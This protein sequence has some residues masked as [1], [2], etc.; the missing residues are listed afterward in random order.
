MLQD[1]F[2]RTGKITR[3]MRRTLGKD[4]KFLMEVL[5]HPDGVMAYRAAAKES[6]RW[7]FDYTDVPGWVNFTRKTSM[8]FF[9]YSYKAIPR[10]AKWLNENP[11]QSFMWRQAFDY[12]NFTNEFMYG[13]HDWEDIYEAQVGKEQV[14]G[15]ARATSVTLPT[16]A[17]R[18]FDIEKQR[19]GKRGIRRRIKRGVEMAPY[20]DVQYWTQIGGLYSAPEPERGVQGWERVA[21]ATIQH[22][23]WTSIWS[24]ANRPEWDKYGSQGGRIWKDEDSSFVALNKLGK[25]LWR[26][27]APPYTPGLPTEGRDDHGRKID[28]AKLGAGL[29]AGGG[30]MQKLMAA[31]MGTPDYRVERGISKLR[32]Y[33]ETIGEMLG[34]RLNWRDDDPRKLRKDL[35][36][37]KKR[38]RRDRDTELRGVERGDR[39]AR[40]DIIQKYDE[41]YEQVE[42]YYKQVNRTIS[43]KALRFTRAIKK[44]TEE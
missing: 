41:Q 11:V 30:S 8:P 40:R 32:E 25:Q 16:G 27:W 42:D 4:N 17:A 35:R 22:P 13:E 2:R 9:T 34:Y 44:A 5:D 3:D 14:P 12:M 10:V 21:N 37:I 15:W 33:D 43:S 38:I 28:Y 29:L 23:L 39:E 31:A 20:W 1:E 19:Y 26:T 18:E 24:L 7:F 36:V 6:H